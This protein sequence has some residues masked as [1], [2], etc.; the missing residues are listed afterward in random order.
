MLKLDWGDAQVWMDTAVRLYRRNV[1]AAEPYQP[2]Q[3]VYPRANELNVAAVCAGYAFELVF[4]VLVKARSGN[5]AAVHEPSEAYEQLVTLR[6]GDQKELDRIFATHEWNDP[7][8]L[9]DFLDKQLC[10]KNRKYWMRPP[11][12]GAAHGVFSFGGR[13]SMD[14]LKL[15]HMDI[16]ALALKSINDRQYV[17]EDWPGLSERVVGLDRS[18]LT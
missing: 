16:P 2:Q 14:A 13:K 1:S 8:E 12:G 3:P 5:P 15:L 11:S 4:K 9:L 10:D 18:P 17:Y 6:P 7:G